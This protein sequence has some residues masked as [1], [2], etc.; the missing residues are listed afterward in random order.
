VLVLE[1][2]IGLRIFNRRPAHM[3]VQLH[4]A[5]RLV[6]S[7]M[8]ILHATVACWLRPRLSLLRLEHD[9]PGSC[10]I[11]TG[12][13]SRLFIGLT[14]PHTRDLF[15]DT[16]ALTAAARGV[17]CEV[18]KRACTVAITSAPCK[19]CKAGSRRSSLQAR[20]EEAQ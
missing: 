18:L 7:R 2:E 9:D 1:E 10:Q 13:R 15:A 11:G 6:A 8:Q 4:V 16:F 14:M 20:C 3:F 5:C 17:G 19:P 12:L